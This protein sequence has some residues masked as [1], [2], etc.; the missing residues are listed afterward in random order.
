MHLGF[1]DAA[2][3]AIG[4]FNPA[5]APVGNFVDA[6]AAAIVDFDATAAPIGNRLLIRRQ[7]GEL[8]TNSCGSCQQASANEGEVSLHS[9]VC[10][11]VY[12]FIH[13]N[14]RR[15]IRTIAQKN[16]LL[17]SWIFITP[18]QCGFAKFPDRAPSI[19]WSIHLDN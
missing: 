10:V 2:A 11:G 9:K 15:P 1:I 17:S 8:A 13:T 3:A 14:L 12:L 19:L 16:L 4:Q 5:A 7:G 18:A 6:P